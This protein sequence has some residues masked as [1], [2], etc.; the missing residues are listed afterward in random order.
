MVAVKFLKWHGAYNAGTIAGFPEDIAEQLVKSGK[1]EYCDAS[2]T[3]AEK[4]PPKR[5]S[6]TEKMIKK[7]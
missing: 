1:A 7:G 3:V 4:A 6:A 2:S 5:T